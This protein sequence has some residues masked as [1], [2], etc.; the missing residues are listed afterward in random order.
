M[1]SRCTRARA[2]PVSTI[3]L[4]LKKVDP[5]KSK[6]TLNVIADDR[7]IEKKDRT[8]GRAAAV[9]YWPRQDALRSG[10][11]HRCQKHHH[12][13]SRHS[14]DRT[15]TGDAVEREPGTHQEEGPSRPLFKVGFS[16]ADRSAANAGRS[17]QCISRTRNTAPHFGFK[18]MSVTLVLTCCGLQEVRLR[19]GTEVKVGG[20]RSFKMKSRRLGWILAVLL[21]LASSMGTILAQEQARTLSYRPTRRCRATLRTTT[22][23]G[24]TTTWAVRQLPP[25]RT[26]L[27]RQ[28]VQD[29]PGR[30]A[31]VQYMSGEVSMQPG[32]VNDWV[33]ASMNRPLTTADRVWTDK[34]SQGRIERGRWFHPHEFRD[35]PDAH[36]RRRQHGPDRT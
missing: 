31:R 8:L 24:R 17:I 13:V 25:G 9:L 12:R 1:T 19:N 28:Q 22:L 2:L 32:G 6:F 21:L 26:T 34:N 4:Q 3:S 11:I 14:Q 16:F 33:A 10:G 36:Q 23:P 30:V 15:H 18:W 5:K 29:P 7:T 35:Q 27:P 20:G